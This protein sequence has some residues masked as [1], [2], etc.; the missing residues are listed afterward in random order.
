MNPSDFGVFERV[1]NFA[2]F[3]KEN[4]P[5]SH[6][7]KRFR[8]EFGHKGFLLKLVHPLYLPVSIRN[9]FTEKI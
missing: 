7:R 5:V 1:K 8:S 2:N 3:A 9:T 6:G 4:K